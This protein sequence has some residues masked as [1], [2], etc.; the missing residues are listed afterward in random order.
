MIVIVGIY[1][2]SSYALGIRPPGREELCETADLR[3][4]CDRVR[5]VA[6]QYFRHSIESEYAKRYR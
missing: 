4:F 2:N 1:R 5:M 6:L 3:R